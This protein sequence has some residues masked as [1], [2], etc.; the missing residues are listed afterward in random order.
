MNIA[1]PRS[2]AHRKPTKLL[3]QEYEQSIY[4]RKD[5]APLRQSFRNL[6]A[7]LKKARPGNKSDSDKPIFPPSTASKP[8]HVHSKDLPLL[9][10]AL[11]DVSRPFLSRSQTQTGTLIYFTHPVWTTCTISLKGSKLTVSWFNDLIPSIHEIDLGRCTDIRSIGIGAL[12][13][14][15]AAALLPF[16][17][18]D[19][20]DG[21]QDVKLFEILFERKQ[22][23]LFAVRSV[24]ERAKW[25]SAFWESISPTHDATPVH[26]QET[27]DVVTETA[28]VLTAPAESTP[29]LAPIRPRPS[30]TSTDRSLP[31][32]PVA[33]NN[34][35]TK[36]IAPALEVSI[37]PP[38]A[39]PTRKNS[40][41]SLG[42][43]PDL[44]TPVRLQVS[45]PSPSVYSSSVSPSVFS[46]EFKKALSSQ[47][48]PTSP[49]SI[50]TPQSPFGNHVRSAQQRPTSPSITNLSQ[51]SVVKS[52]LAQMERDS[53]STGGSTTSARRSSVATKSNFS[54]DSGS[55][56]RKR[57][58]SPLAPSSFEKRGQRQ[59]GS[60]DEETASA[61]RENGSGFTSKVRDGNVK[62]AVNTPPPPSQQLDATPIRTAQ[63]VP[64]LPLPERAPSQSS[65]TSK[66]RA[67]PNRHAG[68]TEYK[69]LDTIS[70]DV[71]KIK[72][73][74]GGGNEQGPG[75][76]GPTIHQ[77]T[78]GLD[79]R[80]VGTNET[81]G[82]V[83]DR[84]ETIEKQLHTLSRHTKG[85]RGTLGY[86]RSD[87][88]GAQGSTATDYA[89]DDE[90]RTG[91]VDASLEDL[92]GLRGILEDIK[93]QLGSEL[94]ALND[95]ISELGSEGHK[96]I[97]ARRDLGEDDEAN[98]ADLKR[99]QGQL[100]ELVTLW[101]TVSR[102][103][104]QTPSA[105]SLEL[106][107]ELARIISMLEYDREDRGRQALQQADSVRYLNELNQW[108]ETFV[109]SGTAQ[110]Q[111]L[112]TNIDRLMTE[113][114]G[115]DQS[116]LPGNGTVHLLNNI[117]QLV[118]GMKA[119]DQNMASLQ[120]SVND[121]I[122]ALNSE[123]R[124]DSSAIAQMIEVQ[125]QHQ[126]V[127][128]R[129]FTDE[130]SG[131]I[132]GERLRFV[133]AMKE[134][135]AINVQQHVEQF[136]E[137][138][139]RE[140]LSVAKELERLQRD[141]QDMESQITNLFSYYSKQQRSADP[142]NGIEIEVPGS[143]VYS[144]NY[145]VG[146]GKRGES[147][148]ANTKPL[149]TPTKPLAVNNN[150]SSG[151]SSSSSR[152]YRGQKQNYYG[153]PGRPFPLPRG[154]Y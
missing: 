18:T 154:T 62:R 146:S 143:G 11:G 141:K 101:Q 5:K 93:S 119:R 33:R 123:T 34:S 84:L 142:S 114:G 4:D 25:I 26:V 77:I 122:T 97:A 102:A 145:G 24:R 127:M 14:P 79:H 117:R 109:N 91:L 121:L 67:T 52:R 7:I 118:L 39:S 2:M 147:N 47:S 95:K 129:S 110:I 83:K 104:D 92:P 36:P 103:H 87:S 108:L 41:L 69:R 85:K 116:D 6:L 78:L 55:D 16:N 61:G 15:S 68:S 120:A 20:G 48:A 29:T 64:G 151:S 27:A 75:N 80:L 139:G 44:P 19:D 17:S 49:T 148:I 43:L 132:K 23:E 51:L 28:P 130:I 57:I 86:Y 8:R 58:G 88:K 111:S 10:L 98:S 144:Q 32:I 21:E 73:V 90:Q 45:N 76:A 107:Q 35:R 46:N 112:A 100:E 63:P 125:K 59:T 136:K 13:P 30:R 65:S 40:N 152:G 105:E 126:K 1:G 106:K 66:T 113:L 135:T 140:V 60:S 22:R 9:P 137:E 54:T 134:A 3:I 70:E 131:E 53:K 115:N 74:L 89:T 153:T 99:L 138:L 124:L 12:D 149:S 81:L 56:L 72:E 150:Q 96:A 94:P 82:L 42:T 128:L 50:R 71:Q 38:I 37:P 31:P 133:E